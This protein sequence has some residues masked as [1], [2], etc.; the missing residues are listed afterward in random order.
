MVRVEI[1]NQSDRSVSFDINGRQ[2]SIP[3]LKSRITYA[4]EGQML[5]YLPKNSSFLK[6]YAIIEEQEK[7]FFYE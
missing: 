7:I 2:F 6:D 5:K 3:S 1:T 4:T